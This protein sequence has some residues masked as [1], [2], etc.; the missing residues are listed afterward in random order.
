M[1]LLETI[2]I[3]G[4]WLRKWPMAAQPYRPHVPN[5]FASRPYTQTRDTL[6]LHK[7]SHYERAL[8]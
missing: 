6:Y 3:G 7:S 8:L 2:N 4:T 5:L 1:N